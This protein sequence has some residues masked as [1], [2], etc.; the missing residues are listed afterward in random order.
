MRLGASLAAP[1]ALAAAV[2][3]APARAACPVEP[4][5]SRFPAA[6]RP[7][8]LIVR[9][10]ALDRDAAG[11]ALDQGAAGVIELTG[12]KGRRVCA[13]LTADLA[14]RG[15]PPSAGPAALVFPAGR[16]LDGLGVS[17]HL[18]AADAA[19]ALGDKSAELWHCEQAALFEPRRARLW[20]RIARLRRELGEATLSDA[21]YRRALALD[22]ASIPLAEARSAFGP[23]FRP[24]A[25]GPT[26]A[27]QR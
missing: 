22:P 19:R 1:L 13:P 9:L 17:G 12:R 18:A 16:R 21:A 20:V 25:S 7:T 4:L 6:Q 5:I 26:V 11:A 27:E 8:L 23:G 2:A 24:R 10:D 14:R 15:W 3:A